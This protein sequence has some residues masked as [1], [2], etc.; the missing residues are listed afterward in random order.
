[1]IRIFYGDDPCD[2]A[3]ALLEEEYAEYP[4]SDP[5]QMLWL[6][7]AEENFQLLVSIL[8]KV[9]HEFSIS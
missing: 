9:K 8:E 3:F 6:A 7:P 1:M 5:G 2:R 4:T